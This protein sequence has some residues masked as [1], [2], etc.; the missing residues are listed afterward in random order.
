MA[1]S[2]NPMLDTTIRRF[3]GKNNTPKLIHAIHVPCTM[4]APPIFSIILRCENAGS[5]LISL[6]TT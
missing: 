3:K 2:F 6:K 5:F 1:V 4:G